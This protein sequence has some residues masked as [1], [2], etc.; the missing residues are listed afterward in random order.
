MI[1][2]PAQH[3]ENAAKPDHQLKNH[4]ENRHPRSQRLEKEG[5]FGPS[6]QPWIQS[7]LYSRK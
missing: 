2:N 3:L 4:Q 1:Q 5:A 7:T 6:G